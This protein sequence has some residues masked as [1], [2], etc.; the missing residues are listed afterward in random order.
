MVQMHNI[1]DFPPAPKLDPS[2][3]LDPALAT[4]QE[5]SGERIFVGKG[6][7]ADCRVPQ[8]EF[9]DN[10]VHDLELERFYKVGQVFN[11][12]LAPTAPSR[13]L[14]CAASRVLHATSVTGD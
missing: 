9:M 11:D 12:F 10:N 5:L 3:R 8:T 4:L 14:C 2:G 13:P 7:C 6:H 1:I